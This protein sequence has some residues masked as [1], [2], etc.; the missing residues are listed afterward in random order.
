MVNYSNPRNVTFLGKEDAMPRLPTML[1]VALS[2]A[3]PAG[4]E[5]PVGVKEPAGVKARNPR[6]LLI[7]SKDCSRCDDDLT[8]L[9]RAGGDFE[10]MRSV[11]WKIGPG[12]DAHLQIVDRDDVAPLVE[13]LGVKEYPTV[14]CLENG[15]IERSFQTGCTTPLDMW[16]FAWLLKGK[17]ERPA[18]SLP[19]KVAVDWTG[20]FPLRGNHWT[21]DGDWS[22][23]RE[24]LIGHLRGP[25]H[26]PQI[27]GRYEIESWS[28]EELRSLHDKLHEVDM[29]GVQYGVSSQG[30][31]QGANPFSAARKASGH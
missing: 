15:Q 24:K 11:G 22:P 6:V 30:A 10:K 23:S 3:W 4:A 5:E 25:V 31:G 1:L 29:G 8:R 14:I 13:Q 2:L 19:E 9:R 21:I 28:Y 27:A 12:V 18:G 17:D 26:G 16:T 20:H 7:V